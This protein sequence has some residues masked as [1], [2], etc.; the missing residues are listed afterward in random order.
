MESSPATIKE[1]TAMIAVVN[2]KPYSWLRYPPRQ[3]PTG[4]LEENSDGITWLLTRFL[5]VV[6]EIALEIS[7]GSRYCRN[8]DNVSPIFSR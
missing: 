1:I 3:A 5:S 2:A 6:S 8:V 7:H 4:I